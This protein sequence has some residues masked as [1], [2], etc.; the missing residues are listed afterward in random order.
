MA[1]IRSIHPGYNRSEDIAGQRGL[2]KLC[3][4]HFAMLWTYC[5]DDG[6]GR[7]SS[8]LIKAECW[9]LDDDVTQRTIDK[10]MDELEGKGRIIRYECDGRR[11]FEVVKFTKWQ[12]PQ[13]RRESEIPPPRLPSEDGSPTV[14][15][16]PNDDRLTVGVE[17]VVVV[18]EGEGEVV[19][20][21]SSDVG[22]STALA[23]VPPDPPS[24][25]A[26]GRGRRLP[27]H[28]E[29]TD[30][31]ADWVAETLP[32]LNVITETAKFCDYWLAVPGAK[33]RKLD[34][35]ATWRNWM[36]KASEY[37]RPRNGN[38]PAARSEEAM[39]AWLASEEA[40]A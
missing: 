38:G 20:E 14:E 32:G 37:A 4:F 40:S 19:G 27:E 35:E 29:V 34:W 3:R 24:P 12:R 10:W 39:L 36:R 2:S 33:G 17:P 7:D 22:V 31:M 21:G 26:P 11:F 16:S 8:A 9:P 1:R 30:A 28:F 15:V 5:D 18:G 13:K 23:V 25:T 6:R